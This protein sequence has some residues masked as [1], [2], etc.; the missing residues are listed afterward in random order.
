[1]KDITELCKDLINQKLPKNMVKI[2]LRSGEEVMIFHHQLLKP[3]MKDFQEMIK[4]IKIFLMIFFHYL[5]V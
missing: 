4:D 1:M 3:R 2:K 5:N